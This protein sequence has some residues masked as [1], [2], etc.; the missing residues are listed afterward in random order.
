M[1][2]QA[3]LLIAQFGA[4][5]A[6]MS[7]ADQL[8]I[9]REMTDLFLGNAA[10]YSVRQVD[11]FNGVM[12][13]LI[14]TADRRCLLEFSGRLAVVDLA[15]ALVMAKLS[16]C[17][18]IAVAGP[19][20]EKSNALTDE[21]LVAVARAKSQDHLSA[22]AAR[23]RISDIVTDVLLERGNPEVARKVVANFG[24]RFSELGFVRVIRGAGTNDA[25]RAALM[26]RTDVPDELMPFLRQTATG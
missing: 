14:E 4:A 26:L 24:A 20:L 10:F 1:T 5:L 22:I 17:D 6:R 15:P 11:I 16:M 12:G 23:A 25:L 3:E 13:H 21:H 19:V 8:A 2:P 9:Q 7:S 18:D